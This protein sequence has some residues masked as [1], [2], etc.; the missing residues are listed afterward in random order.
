MSNPQVLLGFSIK[1]AL[2]ITLVIV[3]LMVMLVALVIVLVKIMITDGQRYSG[4]RQTNGY[5]KS[6]RRSLQVEN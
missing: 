6:G 1:M 3:L 2:A 5:S 4:V